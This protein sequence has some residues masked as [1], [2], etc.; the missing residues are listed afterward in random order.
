MK[1]YN[2]TLVVDDD[3]ISCFIN[4]KIIELS[5]I[6][7]HIAI[8]HN[9]W[10][11]LEYIS[12]NLSHNRGF[13]AKSDLILLDLNMPVMNGFEFLEKFES[14]E[15]GFRDNIEVVVL[16]SSNSQSDIERVKAFDVKSYLSKPLTIEGLKSLFKTYP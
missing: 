8:V 9:G 12:N 13:S 4:Q 11:A 16:T 6:T 10:E 5:N 2:C 1:K 14:W 15:Q 3:P 7:D